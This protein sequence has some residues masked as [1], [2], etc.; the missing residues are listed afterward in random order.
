MKFYLYLIPFFLLNLSCSSGDDTNLKDKSLSSDP[1][2]GSITLT[3]NELDR[4]YYV[5][6]PSSYN[7]TD[8]SPIMFNFHGGAGSI[9]S[10]V[11]RSDMRSLADTNGF[12]LV[13]PQGIGDPTDLSKPEAVWTYK[14]EAANTAVDNLGFVE[15]MID[16][17]STDYNIDL[18]RVY[19][20]GY[21][22]GG[23]FSQELAVR[24]GN[25]IASIASVSSSMQ[26]ETYDQTQILPSNPT[27]VLTI[28]GTEDFYYQYNGTLP[29]FVSLADVN[30]Y[31]INHNK[32]NTSPTVVQVE[33]T[34]TNDGSEVE[35]YTW[36]N[37]NGNVSVE[38]LKI[39]GGG[40]D[41]PGSFGNMDINSDNEIWKFVS[42]YD[43]NGLK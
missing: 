32:C 18:N 22:N 30:N 42:Q 4:E 23:E 5:Y 13:Y 12:I 2:P 37:G 8:T 11:Y 19:A 35:R 25:K 17:L 7:A 14:T 1:F 21:S 28:N 31:W 40:H 41:W 10:A 20:C 24:L 33:N 16:A 26:Q 39:I 36:N 38:H 27:A 34:N 6:V 15:A 29:Y 3:H 43:L 9:A